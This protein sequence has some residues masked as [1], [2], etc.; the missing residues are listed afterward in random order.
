MHIVDTIKVKSSVVSQ[1]SPK[2][3]GDKPLPDVP[4]TVFVD[5]KSSLDKSLDNAVPLK[6]DSQS[7]FYDEIMDTL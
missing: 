3:S 7:S 4:Q 1:F 5:V 6:Y 2:T